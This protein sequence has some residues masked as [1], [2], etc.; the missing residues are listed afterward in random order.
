MCRSPAPRW[1]KFLFV[2]AVFV[3]TIFGSDQL[4]SYYAWVARFVSPFFLF[5]Q[6]VY[7]IDLGARAA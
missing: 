3:G 6:M 5:Y 1:G 4:F 2:G 7:F